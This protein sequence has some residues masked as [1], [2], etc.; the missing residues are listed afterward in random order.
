MYRYTRLLAPSL[1]QEEVAVSKHIILQLVVEV[2]LDAT[3]LV[4]VLN[5]L[6]DWD[7]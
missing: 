4:I 5:L 6:G 7:Q 1:S 2:M 3:D